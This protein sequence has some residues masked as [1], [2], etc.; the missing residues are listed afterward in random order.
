MWATK[1]CSWF[2]QKTLLYLFGRALNLLCSVY[3]IS[4]SSHRKCF[5]KVQR[6]FIRNPF[7]N[8]ALV[9]LNFFKLQMLNIYKH[10]HT[11]TP[12]IFNIF[13]S[14]KPADV[15]VSLSFSLSSNYYMRH[16]L[17]RYRNISVNRPKLSRMTSKLQELL[18]LPNLPIP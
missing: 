4:R 1:N 8:S 15:K 2:S 7:F 18:S 10:Y 16:G 11:E 3:W 12:L 5:I 9:L 6:F 17:L 13:M 14:I